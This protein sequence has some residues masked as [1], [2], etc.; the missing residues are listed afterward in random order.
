MVYSGKIGGTESATFP[1]L[2]TNGRY[3][4]Q[5]HGKIDPLVDKIYYS[6]AEIYCS[7]L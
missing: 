3:A 4:F 6:G 1:A 5:T 2:A 7:D